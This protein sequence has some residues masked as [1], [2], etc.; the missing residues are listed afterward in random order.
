MIKM[1]L[2]KQFFRYLMELAEHDKDLVFL[3]GDLGFNFVE[4]FAQKYPKQYVNCGCLEDSMVD[5]AVGMSL[6]GK[7]P[8]VYSVIN[9]LLFRAYEQVRSDVA[10]EN[11]NVKLVG[12]H[13]SA[14]FG[15][16][17]ISHNIT[18]DEDVKVLSHLPIQICIPKNAR[19][20]HSEMIETYKSK[21]PTYIRL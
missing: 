6:S 10:H 12:Y 8:Y 5:I 16:L 19:K 20:L 9:F 3:T 14:G 13:G 1:D 21:M 4:P 11:T 2:R 17:G 18:E 15:F 7:K